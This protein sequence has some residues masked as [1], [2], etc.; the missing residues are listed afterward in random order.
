MR[1]CEARGA[2]FEANNRIVEGQDLEN[3]PQS[4][5]AWKKDASYKVDSP[6]QGSKSSYR[7]DKGCLHGKFLRR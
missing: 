7:Q 2:H 3:V 1:E 5:F 6:S 4:D